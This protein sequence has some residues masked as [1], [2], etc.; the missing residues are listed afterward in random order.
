MFHS[1]SYILILEVNELEIKEKNH[2]TYL[3]SYQLL[4]LQISQSALANLLK[5]HHSGS[6]TV[7]PIS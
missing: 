2:N 4:D 6:I 3:Q 5:A 1:Y 7:T